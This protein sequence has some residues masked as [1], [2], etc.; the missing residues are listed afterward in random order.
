MGGSGCGRVSGARTSGLGYVI[1]GGWGT[2]PPTRRVRPG[3]GPCS[4]IVVVRGERG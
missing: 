3:H 4:E 2:S 1:A